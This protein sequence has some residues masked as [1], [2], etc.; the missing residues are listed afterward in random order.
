MSGVKLLTRPRGGS[1]SARL[2]VGR[3]SN[4]LTS[5]A[6]TQAAHAR[7]RSLLTAPHTL[8]V[9]NAGCHTAG[10]EYCRIAVD[11]EEKVAMAP[12][13]H[14][15]AQGAKEARPVAIFSRSSTN[16]A[17]PPH[18]FNRPAAPPI[19][20]A[21]HGDSI[22]VPIFEP[23]GISYPEQQRGHV[24]QHDTA[25]H[26]TTQLFYLLRRPTLSAHV[27]P[28]SYN[29]PHPPLSRGQTKRWSHM[30]AAAL[31]RSPQH[32]QVPALSGGRRG[33]CP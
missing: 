22:S 28:V 6:R 1:L 17:A 7:A 5:P 8:Q 24:T 15:R 31:R 27:K 3:R 20:A 21:L 16:R 33:V 12:T 23:R 25:Q 30:H 10:G 29:Q 13:K 2:V 11:M 4:Y 19:A 18:L 14:G 26:E 9:I 32:P